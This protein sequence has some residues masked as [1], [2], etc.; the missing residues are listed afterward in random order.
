MY[1]FIRP[2]LFTVP[3]ELAHSFTMNTL[4]MLHKMRLSQLL[5][6]KLPDASPCEVMG[7]TFP[8]PIGLA[9]GLDKN[10]DYLDALGALG[11]G[12]IEVGTLTPRPQPGNPPPRIFRI[13]EA[14]A[15][16]NRLGFN[17]K[18][19]FYALKN[20]EKHQF[21]GILGVN[22]GKNQE[23]PL[24]KALVDYQ[25]GLEL[26]YNFADYVTV[27]ISSPNTPGLRRLQQVEFL[28]PMLAGLK[29]AQQRLA[30]QEG[31]YVPIVIKIAPDLAVEA[32]TI[33]AKQLLKYQIDGVI[34]TNTT[35]S[36]EGVAG[37][38]RA[39]ESGGLSGAPLAHIS[40]GVI[41]HL[42]AILADEIP[43]IAAGGVMN[44][45]D[46]RQKIQAGAQLVQIYTG[47][48][49]QGPRFVKAL[50]NT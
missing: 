20:F 16:I 50:L 8:N 27:N 24:E 37:L 44:V 26:V 28:E 45:E 39:E 12:F 48:I 25:H 30:D 9:A 3:P 36:R 18:G 49:Y 11:F 35:L 42:H 19:I 2:V 1:S 43:I 14:Q 29:Q 7:L 31:H 5:V 38:P 4:N 41:K 15:M 13:P 21:K 33:I 47:L 23:T 40:T 10:G 17:N 46:V 22:I 6:G 32:I 34:A